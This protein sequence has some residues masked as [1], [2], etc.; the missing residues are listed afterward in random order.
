MMAE[1]LHEIWIQA[2][3]NGRPLEGCCL[4]GPAG[5]DFRKLLNPDAKLVN[6]FKANCHF[7]AMNIYYQYCDLE[8]YISDRDWDHEPYPD[9][10]AQKQKGITNDHHCT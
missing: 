9:A 4:A 5:E 1:L 6:I 2:D 8:T 3:E 10:W 7:E